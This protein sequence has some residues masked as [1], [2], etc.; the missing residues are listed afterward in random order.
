MA[1]MPANHSCPVCGAS[2]T[3]ASDLRVY[4]MVDHRKSDL[5]DCL[6]DVD[7]SREEWLSA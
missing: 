3:T 4:L 2:R 1:V 6:V 7:G 5:T